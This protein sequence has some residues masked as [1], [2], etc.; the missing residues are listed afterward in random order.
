MHRDLQS[1]SG[2]P[3]VLY[4]GLLLITA[5]ACSK[6]NLDWDLS[7]LGK[8]TGRASLP[9]LA[10]EGPISMRITDACSA[11]FTVALVDET[12]TR[13]DASDEVTVTLLGGGS[14]QFF[15]T[16]A[17]G[18]GVASSTLRIPKGGN[19]TTFYLKNGSVGLFNV[20][21]TSADLS[22]SAEHSYQVDA[23]LVAQVE[24]RSAIIG[25]SHPVDACVP[26]E[27]A[28]LDAAGRAAPT[29][30]PGS[31][32]LDVRI[33]GDDTPT[34]GDFELFE[35]AACVGSVPLDALSD[36][37]FFA[38]P[39]MDRIRFWLKVST[40]AVIDLVPTAPPGLPINSMTI[41]PVGA[42]AVTQLKFSPQPAYFQVGS[43]VEL[44]VY[45]ADADGLSLAP[46][47]SMQIRLDAPAGIT[48]YESA[49]DCPGGA[50]QAAP[51]PDAGAT[52]SV[53]F[54]VR[55]SQKGPV[56]VTATSVS[57][58]ATSATANLNFINKAIQI[59]SGAGNSCALTEAGTVLCWGNNT[60][61]QSDPTG[62]SV[63][64]SPPKQI[65]FGG[66][67][68]TGVAVGNKFA[69]ATVYDT[70]GGVAREK[71]MCWGQ[72]GIGQIPG[73]PI[74]SFIPPT[75][76]Y[77]PGAGGAFITIVAGDSHACAL[78]AD[79][80]LL[81]W[82]SNS[83]G[84]TGHVLSFGGITAP[85]AVRSP[86]SWVAASGNN[87]CAQDAD[88]SVYCWGSNGS[89]QLGVSPLIIPSTAG[90]QQVGASTPAFGLGI[91]HGCTSLNGTTRCLGSNSSGQLGSTVNL[92]TT[93][94]NFTPVASSLDRRLASGASITGGVGHTC[95]VQE[96]GIG[97]ICVG[98]NASGQLG[99]PGANSYLPKLVNVGVNPTR[100]LSSGRYHVCGAGQD[101]RIVCWGNNTNGQCGRPA[102]SVS[103]PHW[104]EL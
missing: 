14:P 44:I 76:V 84:Q 1:V 62:A 32:D 23:A 68:A 48:V 69:C 18:A 72:N 90:P 56:A 12:G 67:F 9:S 42:S 28:F 30:N 96:G 41:T 61:G 50:V 88:D 93:Q 71:I 87:T 101:G 2:V 65:S 13:I 45:A 94:P 55:T 89:G 11:A 92:N 63:S 66:L 104:F 49:G 77:D 70:G 82:G 8:N 27:F 98:D 103:G 3:R 60:V 97:V 53:R 6:A 33:G 80:T 73:A 78:K 16:A 54:W 35:D 37:T 20:T 81:C 100:G 102:T 5:T 99:S 86:T 57:V 52:G 19:S 43:C 31:I 85:A 36:A 24:T 38:Y 75:T 29:A 83:D 58:A 39:G 26:Y 15:L 34:P 21:A 51:Y 25:G 79:G 4:T 22:A 91:S 10:I 64:S 95:A 17:C 74:Q 59:A 40:A 7:S 47:G 46:G